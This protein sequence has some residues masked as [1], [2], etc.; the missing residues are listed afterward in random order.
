M[1]AQSKRII[2]EGTINSENQKLLDKYE[3]HI[4]IKNL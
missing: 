4:N 1:K 2:I 3:Q